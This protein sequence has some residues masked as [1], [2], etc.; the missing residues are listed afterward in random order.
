MAGCSPVDPR[1]VWRGGVDIVDWA[2]C[3]RRASGAMDSIRP[4]LGCTS[5]ADWTERA[6]LSCNVLQPIGSGGCVGGLL[7]LCQM[8]R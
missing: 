5:W 8:N 3:L 2:R 7:S 4:G 1:R 6:W